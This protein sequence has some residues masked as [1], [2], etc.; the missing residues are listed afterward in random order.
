MIRTAAG[1]EARL[2]R[3]GIS[4]FDNAEVLSGVREGE[5]VALLS[6]AEQAAKRKSTQ[7]DMAKRVGGAMT[8][9]SSTGT[10]ATGGAH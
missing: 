1:F 6:V 10:R 3:L 5:V 9:S 8:G 2:V 4:D 7:A